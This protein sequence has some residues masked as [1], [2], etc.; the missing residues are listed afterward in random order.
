MFSRVSLSAVIIVAAIVWACIVWL[1]G[2][3]LS[4]EYIT[5]FGA[6][7]TSVSILLMLFE[8]VLWRWWPFYI[9]SG[10][11]DLRGD[12]KIE[13]R[14]NYV[15]PSNSEP[16]QCVEGTAAVRQTL[17]SLSI[18]TDTGSQTSF[19]IAYNIIRH[20]DGVYEVVGVYQ[21]DPDL[22][23][24]GSYSEIHYG[25]FRYSINGPPI[26]EMHGNYW[27]DR[28]TRGKINFLRRINANR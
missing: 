28:N 14:S 9:F 3:E 26:T 18:R 13:V 12:W 21:S 17:S 1:R 8:R 23:L 25:A 22:A 2:G 5:P 6:V 24:R 7:I 11:P 19:L 20:G 4:W 27:T 16:S 15:D 10:I